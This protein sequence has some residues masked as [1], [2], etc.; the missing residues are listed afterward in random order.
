[1][2]IIASSQT[3]LLIHNDGF[4]C[5]INMIFRIRHIPQINRLD[6]QG[7]ILNDRQGIYSSF[8]DVCWVTGK[9]KLCITPILEKITSQL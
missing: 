3:Q 1:M 9:A 2:D 6:D 7:D 8:Y 5:I 4:V